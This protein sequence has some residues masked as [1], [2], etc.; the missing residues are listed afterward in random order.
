MLHALSIYDPS[1]VSLFARCTCGQEWL[2][3]GPRKDAEFRSQFNTHNPDAGATEDAVTTYTV[4]SLLHRDLSYPAN[5]LLSTGYLAE[6]LG[7]NPVRVKAA[8]RGHEVEG[9]KFPALPFNVIEGGATITRMAEELGSQ[10]FTAAQA[11][12]ATGVDRKT[13]YEALAK[14]K[15]AGRV[16]QLSRGSYRL[17]S[18]NEVA[19]REVA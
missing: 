17:N 18:R 5:Q 16:T 7:W 13:L 11:L 14:L 9:F 15:K 1:A 3:I 8:L 4:V 2:T 19:V 6:L 12:T 10:P